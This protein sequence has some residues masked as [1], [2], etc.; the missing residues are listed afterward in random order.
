MLLHSDILSDF[1][2]INMF[3]Y[4]LLLHA[5]RRSNTDRF[6]S[7][8]FDPNGSLTHHLPQSRRVRIQN[9]TLISSNSSNYYNTDVVVEKD[10]NIVLS[11]GWISFE[12][13]RWTIRVTQ[14][15]RDNFTDV[16]Q[17]TSSVSYYLTGATFLRIQGNTIQHVSSTSSIYLNCDEPD[18]CSLNGKREFVVQENKVFYVKKWRTI[19]SWTGTDYS[20]G[21]HELTPLCS[22]FGFLYCVMSTI[23]GPFALF[24]FIIVL[25]VLQI[26]AFDY[27]LVSPNMSYKVLVWF[28]IGWHSS[29]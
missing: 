15:P 7:L 5:Y 21:A 2:T 28:S 8:W 22:I 12:Q 9:T 6:G 10:D 29:L 24:V 20:S 11:F 18:S 23:V 14:F 4:S 27:S 25:S 17:D 3:S 1:E 26:N 16:E 19:T 13:L